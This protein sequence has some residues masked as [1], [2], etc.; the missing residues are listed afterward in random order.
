[1]DYRH[2][3][4]NLSS[5]DGLLRGKRIGL[6]TNPSGVDSQLR[7]VIDILAEQYDLVRL[8]A[9]EHGV[10]GDRQAGESVTGYTDEKTGLPVESLFGEGNDGRLN[11]RDLDCIVYDI[12]DVGVRFFSYTYTMAAAMRACAD[13]QI[14][15]VILDR[16]N[17][18]GLSTVCGS[19]IEPQFDSVVGGFGLPTRHGMTI[20]ELAR[21]I[22]GE[23]QFGC[24]LHVIACAGLRRSMD[25]RHCNVPWILPSPNCAGY[26]TVLCY[27]GT[28]L[29]EGT[30]VS[31]GRGTVKPFELIGAPWMENDTVVKRMEEKNFAGVRFRSAYFR[32]TFS[33]YRGEL[34]KGLQMHITDPD[35]FDAFSC[36]LHLLQMIRK[37]HPEFAF[38]CD[39][40]S[41]FID[42]LAGTDA[43][44]S[45]EFDPD[46]FLAQQKI[47]V[48]KFR[49]KAEKYWLYPEG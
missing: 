24:E 27:A 14:P 11:T 37:L 8:F 2:G 34:C 9:P 10:R 33:K 6:I 39:S 5:Q 49:Q 23:Y 45:A 40:G 4:E 21:Y 42:N 1:M 48:E 20:G 16:Y 47:K 15:F 44:R 7:S 12:Q 3:I 38:G 19:V 29:F 43:L 22:N 18:L 25:H 30:N 13:A 35:R 28:V 32:P 46:V 41:N 31:E 26:E 36:T 17:P